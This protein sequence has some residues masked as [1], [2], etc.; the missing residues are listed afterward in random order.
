MVIWRKPKEMMSKIFISIR[1]VTHHPGRRP[2]TI[3]VWENMI[4]IT[5]FFGF[6]S[7]FVI[8]SCHINRITKKENKKDSIKSFFSAFNQQKRTK[9]QNSQCYKTPFYET[10]NTHHHNAHYSLYHTFRIPFLCTLLRL[11]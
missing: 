9:T 8:Q 7:F 11:Q 4:M 6:F 2:Y 5:F 1:S 3:V 10:Q